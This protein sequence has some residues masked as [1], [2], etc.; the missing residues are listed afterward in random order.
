MPAS[1]P[2]PRT[3]PTCGSALS[4]ASRSCSTAPSPAEDLVGD[5]QHAMAVAD[6]A[7]PPEVIGPRRRGPGRGSAHRLRDEGGDVL[8]TQPLDRVLERGAAA[9]GALR[10]PATARA[11][12]GIR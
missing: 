10:I 4:A 2:R 8:G 9:P 12:V 7:D 5:E 11:A 3:S 6:L 1:S